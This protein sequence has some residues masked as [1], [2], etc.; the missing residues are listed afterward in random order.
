LAELDQYADLS[1]D[2]LAAELDELEAA[3]E[4]EELEE[5]DELEAELAA[6]EAD[7]SLEVDVRPAAEQLQAWQDTVTNFGGRIAS[8]AKQKTLLK[9]LSAGQLGQRIFL[10]TTGPGQLLPKSVLLA[11][12]DLSQAVAMDVTFS[13]TDMQP[14]AFGQPALDQGN[15]FVRLTWG[16]PGTFRR[17]AAIDGNRGWR[18]QFSASFMRVEYVLFAEGALQANPMPGNQPRDLGVA[19][20]I[21]PAIGS[22]SQT[23]TK[24]VFMGD[25]AENSSTSEVIPRWA[26]HCQI[27]GS[28]GDLDGD[29]DVLL[30]DATIFAVQRWGSNGVQ[31]PFLESI[32]GKYPVPQRAQRIFLILGNNTSINR[33]TA[34]FDLAL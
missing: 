4:L 17:T 20:M 8:P 32:I 23:L 24:T 29:Y 14:A 3:H 6:L 21:S 25:I 15:G 9:E 11:Q 2:E 19:A 28:W 22:V 34:I 12:V 30:T 7:P 18:R 5:L 26:T 1:D 31:A 13:Y 16:S 27:A 33:A 10:A